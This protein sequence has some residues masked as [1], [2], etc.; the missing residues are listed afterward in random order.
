MAQERDLYNPRRRVI[1]GTFT[2]RFSIT[3]SLTIF[4]IIADLLGVSWIGH[5]LANRQRNPF[6]A[7]EI[8][9]IFSFDPKQVFVDKVKMLRSS[10]GSWRHR[11]EH[12]AVDRLGLDV[13]L[14]CTGTNACTQP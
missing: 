1:G 10:G 9:V 7:V 11:E 3:E 14:G 6:Y 12:M 5:K 8:W 13:Q 4:S 2:A